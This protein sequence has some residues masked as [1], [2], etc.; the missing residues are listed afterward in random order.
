MRTRRWLARGLGAILVATVLVACTTEPE[1]KDES[2]EPSVP[3]TGPCKV[4]SERGDVV[5]SLTVSG[6]KRS[7]LLY[8]PEGLPTDERLPVVFVFHGLGQEPA[9]AVAYTGFDQAAADEGFIVVAPLGSVDGPGWTV[10]TKGRSADASFIAALN[11]AV[12]ERHCADPEREYAVGM[13]NGSALAVELAC[14]GEY[15]FAAYGGVAYMTY[16]GCD[17]APPTS[18]IYFHGTSDPAVPYTG[19]ATPLGRVEPVID[20]LTGWLAHD[21]CGEPQAYEEPAADLQHFTWSCPS[22]T[23]ETYVV[24]GG[25]H[26]WPGSEGVGG[27]GY[28]TESVSATA[29]M[30]RFFDLV[31]AD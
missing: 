1:K 29:E 30:L 10:G 22:S 26:T 21:Q 4:E 11:E 31:R 2:A 6:K 23:I 18:F 15:P 27:Q 3:P 12:V 20:S 19:G 24:L 9:D 13:S 17:S 16:D 8:A 5:H 7:Y 28:T 25:G 14:T